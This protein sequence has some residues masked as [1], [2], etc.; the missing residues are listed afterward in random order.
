MHRPGTE[1]AIFRSQVRRPNH[2]TTEPPRGAAKRL[3]ED[4]VIAGL[5]VTILVDVSIDV[6]IALAVVVCKSHC[7]SC[8]LCSRRHCGARLMNGLNSLPV[9]AAAAVN[10]LVTQVGQPTC[11]AGASPLILSAAPVLA[12]F[13]PR[14][15][16][17]SAVLSWYCHGKSPVRPS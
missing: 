14:D 7:W 13:L 2:Y 6:A 9:A 11:I 1:L 4:A 8:V 15:A 3:Q 10:T 17:Q 16:M 12:A 5:R